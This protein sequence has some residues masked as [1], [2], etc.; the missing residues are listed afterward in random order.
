MGGWGN[1]RAL[2]Q[3]LDWKPKGEACIVMQSS[4]DSNYVLILP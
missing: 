3:A 1:L 4:K 2:I